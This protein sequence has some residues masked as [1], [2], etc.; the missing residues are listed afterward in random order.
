MPRC[1]LLQNLRFEAAH[2]PANGDFRR[3]E[4]SLPQLAAITNGWQSPNFGDLS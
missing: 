3:A 4:A 1:F 2:Q